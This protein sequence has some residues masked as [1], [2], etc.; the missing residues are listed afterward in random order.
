MS[1]EKNRILKKDDLNRESRE[2]EWLTSPEREEIRRRAIK[3]S[4][5][6]FEKVREQVERLARR[7]RSGRP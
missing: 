2:R 1:A 7:A 6:A 5:R 4:E 3:D